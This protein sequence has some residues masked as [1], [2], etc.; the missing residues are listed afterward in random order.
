M[1]LLVF[2][3]AM[4]GLALLITLGNERNRAAIERVNQT[5]QEWA[6][7]DLRLKRGTAQ[8][9]IE[10]QDTI[11]W[12]QSATSKALGTPIKLSAPE[13]L[14]N[15]D[16]LLC[17]EAETGSVFAFST[18]SPKELQRNLRG[19]KKNALD[20]A[21]VN[22]LGVK[23]KKKTS[24]IPMNILNAGILF[25]LELPIVWKHL[26]GQHLSTEQLWLYIIP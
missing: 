7:Q 12:L 2:I 3:I 22:P 14:S 9:A 21:S 5:A 17:F 25:D 8:K 24:V 6:M 18:Y 19:K 26:T 16:A 23:L 15:P 20:G 4:A 13:F 11:H 10:I 1:D